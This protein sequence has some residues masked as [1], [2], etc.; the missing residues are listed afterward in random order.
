MLAGNS[1]TAKR[2]QGDQITG[3]GEDYAL[4]IVSRYLLLV[5]DESGP[6]KRKASLS[7]R[8]TDLYNC[9]RLGF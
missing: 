8:L 3:N 7:K 4:I 2:E 5:V 1:K 9:S 6:L